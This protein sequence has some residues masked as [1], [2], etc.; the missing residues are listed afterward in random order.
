[1]TSGL[2]FDDIR[3]LLGAL[4][5]PAA[6]L[7]AETGPLGRLDELSAWYASWTGRVQ[8]GVQR[9]MSVLFA[10]SHGFAG[11]NAARE[12]AQV[13]LNRISKGEEPV[14]AICGQHELGLKVFDLALHLPTADFTKEAALDEKACAATVAYGMEAIAGGIDLIGVTCTGP[15]T[16]ESAFAIC[17]ALGVVEASH[18]VAPGVRAGAV[19]AALDFHRNHFGDP[20]EVL[21]RLGGRESA[22]AAGAILAARMERVPVVLGSPGAIAAAAVLRSVEPS[23]ADHCVVADTGQPWTAAAA[24]ALGR[25][26]LVDLRIS[27]SDG[28][29]AAI[30][31][32]LVKTASQIGAGRTA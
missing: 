28:S 31:M 21:R 2:P 16:S 24:A 4:P 29:A 17:R 6:D 27:S 1:M 23:A 3:N 7:A 30:G 5:G 15:G 9:P 20:L 25:P 22:A 14:N 10:S 11:D 8:G 12:A 32:L 18:P 19:D 13:H 26:A